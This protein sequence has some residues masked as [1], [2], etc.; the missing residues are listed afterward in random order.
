M[1]VFHIHY[2]HFILHI[3]SVLGIRGSL[4]FMCCCPLSLGLG[5]E[6]IQKYWIHSNLAQNHT[7]QTELIGDRHNKWNDI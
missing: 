4:V 6:K 1:V 2:C 5:C 7:I 3:N